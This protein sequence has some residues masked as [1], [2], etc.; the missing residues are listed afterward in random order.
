MTVNVR[1]FA[2]IGLDDLESVGGKNASLGEMITNL[3]SA[4]VLVPNGFVTT[5]ADYQRLLAETGLAESINATLAGLDTDDVRALAS[6]GSRLR[7]AVMAQAFPPD[8]EADVRAAYA[9]L[10]GAILTHPSPSGPAPPRKTCPMHR[11]P[12]S[13]RPSS[14]SGE[15]TTS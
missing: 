12:V 2:D 7:A 11:S 13:R 15:S 1:W 14:T 9:D 8:L 10:V 4:G 5:T 3:T 6:A